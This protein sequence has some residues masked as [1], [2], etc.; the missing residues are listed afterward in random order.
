MV[1]DTVGR[2]EEQGAEGLVLAAEAV[3]V[4]VWGSE[5]AEG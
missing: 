2:L 3:E 1:Q 5:A 4:A